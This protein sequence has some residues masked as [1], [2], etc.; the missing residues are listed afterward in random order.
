MKTLLTLTFALLF[1]T[2]AT[3]QFTSSTAQNYANEVSENVQGY[4]DRYGETDDGDYAVIQVNEHI[5]FSLVRTMVGMIASTHSDVRVVRS[6]QREN[7][8]YE[9]GALIGRS[10]LMML[11]YFPETNQIIL[12]HVE[13]D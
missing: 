7:D 5:S 13:V 8:Y 2:T 1:T 12:G 9:Y 11:L 6:W 10:D 3:A 4:I